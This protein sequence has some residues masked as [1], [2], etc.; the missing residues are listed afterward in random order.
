MTLLLLV[1]LALFFVGMWTLNGPF[2]PANR[3]LPRIY[4]SDAWYWEPDAEIKPRPECWGGLLFALAG[5]TAYVSW[6]RRDRL[7]RNLAF[8]GMLAGGLG[9][10]LGQCVQAFHAWNPKLFQSGLLGTL[11]PYMNW[12]N[13]M[14]ISF[15]AIFGGLLAA[16]LWLNRQK[17]AQDTPRDEVVVSPPWELALFAAQVALLVNAEFVGFSIL[18]RF[19]QFGLL[20]AVFPFIGI[21]GGRYWPYLFSLVI[22]AVP[23]AGKTLRELSYSNAEISKPLGWILYVVIP[24]AVTLGVALWLAHQGKKGQT[25]GPL[26]RVGLLLTT[27][28]YFGL[29]FVFFRFPWPWKEWTGRTPSGIIFVVCALS[30]TTAVVVFPVRSRRALDGQMSG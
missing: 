16:G 1:M 20:M 24:L 2:D 11:D 12:W 19:I 3:V 17:I 28:L 13:M 29:N 27:W 26:A 21:L 10:S 5:L 7:A 8:T 15:G 14:E 6:I 4:F 25:S 18:A 23:I 30:L 22:V 9:F